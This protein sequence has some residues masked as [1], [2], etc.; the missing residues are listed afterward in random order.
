M[1]KKWALIPEAIVSE[2]DKEFKR[3]QEAELITERQWADFRVVVLRVLLSRKVMED[4]DPGFMV[5]P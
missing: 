2:L 5:V 3:I 4:R 1:T